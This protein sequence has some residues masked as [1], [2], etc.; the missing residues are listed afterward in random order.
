M[1]TKSKLAETAQF[2]VF[3]QCT[4]STAGQ[5]PSIG[6]IIGSTR[7]NCNGRTIAFWI[8]KLIQQEDGLQCKY[9][10]IDLA[11]WNLPLFNEPGI[12]MLFSATLDHSKAWSHEIKALDGFLFVTPQVMHHGL[13]KSL[14]FTHPIY[15]KTPT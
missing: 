4:A 5:I 8:Q 2:Q 3:E 14:Q 11:D 13:T 7:P 6:I 10:V 9:K 12:P 1:V 15:R